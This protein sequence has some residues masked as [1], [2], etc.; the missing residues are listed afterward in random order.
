MKNSALKLIQLP[1]N[2]L[3]SKAF[4]LW[5]IGGW[6]LYYVLSAIWAREAFAGFISGLEGNALIRIPFI[7]FLVSGYFN[8][9]RA[10]VSVLKKGGIQFFLWLLLP[11]GALIFFTGFFI[12]VSLKQ[13]EQVIVGEGDIVQPSWSSDSYMITKINPGLRENITD[14]DA[15]KGIFAYEP[16]MTLVDRN[17]RPFLV[18]AY[19]PEKIG[20]TFFHILNF[21]LAPGVRLF[22]K[23]QIKSEGYMALKI[24]QPGSSDLF[25]I[26]G[27]PYRFQVSMEP[28]KI[29][30]GEGGIVS[31]YNLK[32]PVYKVK[33]YRDEEVIA[34]GISKE[35]IKFD[36]LDIGF[37]EPVFWSMLEIVNDP[38]IR[39][40]KTG[41]LLIVI[42]L[43]GT[44]SRIVASKVKK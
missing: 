15:W 12:S 44:L 30:Q 42:G 9:I 14:M 27:Y 28:E 39:L 36:D 7:L 21:G 6:I 20:N 8:L 19:P 29:F 2:V 3:S 16:K 35:G 37:Y 43:P 41:I 25:E 1:L 13:I 22:E 18:G 10:S 33:V 4:F 38:G 24:L 34:E 32:L 31:R 40:I 5:I 11:L 26:E 17:S 23:N